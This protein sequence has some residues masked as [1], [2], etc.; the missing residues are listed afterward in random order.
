MS[1]V[2]AATD[3]RV[4]G[5][6][7]AV[8]RRLALGVSER[9][10]ELSDAIAAS[11]P[12]WLRGSLRRAIGRAGATAYLAAGPVPPPIGLCL[13]E[14]GERDAWI[15]RLRAAAPE[16]EISAGTVSP[17]AIVVRSA[18]DVRKLPGWNEAWI[19]Q[20]E[21]SQ[22]VAL[23][24][25]VRAGEHVLDACAGRGNKGWSLARLVGPTGSV[26][27]ADL[28]PSKLAEAAS[29]GIVAKTFAVRLERGNGNGR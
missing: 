9:R 16:A 26:D 15:D 11:A 24:T 29:R 13:A 4:G 20:E 7:N 14:P 2:S 23:A 18:G 3:S 19:V 21:G 28:Y 27:A 17:R 12:G 22:I 10:P 5:F 6:A 1:G 8:L 25:G